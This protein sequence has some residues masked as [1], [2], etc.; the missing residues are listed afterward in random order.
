MAPLRETI[1]RRQMWRHP[2]LCGER[3]GRE[4]NEATGEMTVRTKGTRHPFTL[5]TW[6]R[7]SALFGGNPSQQ[8]K[9]SRA[10]SA[11]V[12]QITASSSSPTMCFGF[13][14]GVSFKTAQLIVGARTCQM[15][16]AIF[17]IVL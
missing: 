16:R 5:Q 7:K 4:L 8:A 9:M 11:K 10:S 17:A 1:L 15:S 2:S 6:R 3:D 13:G 14:A 12:R